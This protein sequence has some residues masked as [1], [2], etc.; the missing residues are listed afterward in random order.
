MSVIMKVVTALLH[1]RPNQLI[2]ASTAAARVRARKRDAPIPAS[3]ARQCTITHS[4]IEGMP[5]VTLMPRAGATGTQLLYLHGGAYVNSIVA[6]H[7][8]IVG[9][10]LRESGATVTVPSYPLAPEHTATDVFP[11]LLALYRQLRATGSPVVFAG[12]SAGGGLALSLSIQLRDAEEVPP[13][14]LVLFS[15]A[16]DMTMTNP[17]IAALEPRDP[18][19]AAAGLIW[20]GQQWAGG[21]KTTDPR[22]SPV[23]DALSDLPPTYIYQGGHDILTPDVTLLAAKLHTAGT[24]AEL[25]IYP[26]GCHV[27]VGVPFA[28]EARRALRHAAEAVM[29]AEA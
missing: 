19:L 29:A 16:A 11:K 7:W 28:P 6:P 3:L 18:M 26:D 9:S 21:L 10:L 17:D 24:P 13:A 2:S 20:C 27:F 25:R 23:Y 8:W 22:I 1:T 15:P 14:A 4:E 5:V 12:D